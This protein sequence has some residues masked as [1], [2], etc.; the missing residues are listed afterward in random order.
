LLFDKGV[1]V[2]TKRGFRVRGWVKGIG[3]IE[4]FASAWS[5]PQAIFLVA[6]RLGGRYPRLEIFIEDPTV[7]EIKEKRARLGN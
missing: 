1:A 2:K 4:E 3:R 7:T 6:R 5:E